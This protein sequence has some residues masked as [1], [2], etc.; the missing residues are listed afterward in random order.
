M[1]VLTTKAKCK[2]ARNT[3]LALARE[4][5]MAGVGLDCYAEFEFSQRT[6]G[7]PSIKQHQLWGH[8]IWRHP[9]ILI[10]WGHHMPLL[11]WYL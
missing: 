3:E 5:H 6:P 4:L 8:E 1:T 9:R 7:G 10:S 11:A 2:A